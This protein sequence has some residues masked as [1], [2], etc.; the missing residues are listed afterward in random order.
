MPAIHAILS[1]S[2]E[3]GMFFVF[4]A[5][6]NAHRVVPGPLRSAVMPGMQE[7]LQMIVMGADGRLNRML[8][9]NLRQWG[10][11]VRLWEPGK[12]WEAEEQHEP[13]AIL[14]VDLDG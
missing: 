2:Q 6:A 9:Q 5:E 10:Y 11:R 8:E 1:P 7:P 13:G 4:T 3:S 12:T 14:I